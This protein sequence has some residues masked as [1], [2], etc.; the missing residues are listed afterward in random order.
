MTT[1]GG[2]QNR[3]GLAAGTLLS[4]KRCG[5]GLVS[6]VLATV[7][8]VA[9]FR[10]R[11]SDGSLCCNVLCSPRRGNWSPTRQK[12]NPDLGRVELKWLENAWAETSLGV[13]VTGIDK[14]GT[15]L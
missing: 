10:F 1:A 3:P 5:S 13:S 9:P 6:L 2:E 12:Y 14:H 11:R 7:V 8:A 4:T 15:L